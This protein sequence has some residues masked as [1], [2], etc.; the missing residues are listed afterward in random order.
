MLEAERVAQVLRS[1][2]DPKLRTAF[3]RDYLASNPGPAAASVFEALCDAGARA[4]S[5]AQEPVLAV[6]VFLVQLHD[7]PLLEALRETAHELGLKH[8]GRLLQRGPE[9]RD[10]KAPSRVPD[11]GVGRELSL[12]ERKTLA[13]RPNRAAFDRLL[14]DPNAQVIRQLLENPRLTEDDVIRLAARRPAQLEALRTLAKSQ[15]LSRPRV[16][17]AL[18]HNPATPTE[19]AL[20]LLA[21]CTRPELQEVITNPDCPGLLRDVAAEL[22]NLRSL[23]PPSSHLN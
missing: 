9:Q 14:R 5:T 6:V 4:R 16:R 15:W 23:R 22:S 17:I 11:Y 3:L 1:L 7:D 13:R 12:G 2:L 8:L 10:S 18:I 20:P 21:A 19:I